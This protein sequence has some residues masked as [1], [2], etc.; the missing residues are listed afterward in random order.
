VSKAKLTL[1]ELVDH[2]D[3]GHRFFYEEKSPIAMFRQG[4]CIHFHRG[5]IE[6]LRML[7]DR[8]VS[9]TQ[10]CKDREYLELL[11][12]TLTAWGMNLI[13]MKIRLLDFEEFEKNLSDPKLT[14]T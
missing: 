1:K 11:Y 4:P 12:A 3:E 5:K 10:I 9:Y 6:K 7:L 13:G 2:F 14:E 8:S